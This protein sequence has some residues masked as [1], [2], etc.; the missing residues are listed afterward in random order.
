M[1]QNKFERPRYTQL[2]VDLFSDDFKDWGNTYNKQPSVAQ[3]HSSPIASH[4]SQIINSLNELTGLELNPSVEYVS[5]IAS[6]VTNHNLQSNVS[7]SLNYSY[8]YEQ[9][10]EEN[11]NCS[12]LVQRAY[13]ELR[14]EYYDIISLI[15]IIH[16]VIIFVGILFN[17]LNLLVLLKSK[18]HESPYTYLTMLALSDL[19]A[20]IMFVLER[21]R[22]LF[23]TTN[24]EFVE[25]IH[26]Y[27][28]VLLVNVFLSSS[29]YVT[30]A[31]TIERFIFVHSPFKAMSICR[32]S[33]ARR[34]C[35]GIFI[36][37]FVR[38]LYLPFMYKKNCLS[39]HDQHK[40]DF[41]DFY[42][43]VVSLAL[44][45]TIIFI[46]NISLIFSLNRQNNLMSASVSTPSLASG[47]NAQKRSKT[48]STLSLSSLN[49]IKKLYIV[50]YC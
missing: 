33:I 15:H 26:L 47:S 23:L 43:F 41:I 30:L 49:V 42:E 10:F 22:Q 34:V 7:N 1:K 29:M 35:L 6:A 2:L 37:S 27:V 13:A 31:L 4:Q 38:L 11:M 3:H 46:A 16:Y 14:N 17:I 45:Y 21:I 24:S 50:S 25:N 5:K 32:R 36:F 12:S 28:I 40:F 8:V 20:L 48:G 19:G 9:V 44:P 39:G 18:L